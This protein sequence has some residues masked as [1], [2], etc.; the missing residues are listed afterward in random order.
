MT[1]FLQP[2]EWIKL[3]TKVQF[4]CLSKR[5]DFFLNMLRLKYI[6]NKMKMFTLKQLH[7]FSLYYIEKKITVQ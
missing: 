7:L 6:S 1:A 3:S 2:E 4:G 5:P